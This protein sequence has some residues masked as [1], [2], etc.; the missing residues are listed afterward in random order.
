MSVV[1]VIPARGGSK[2]IPRKNLALVCGQPL[3][4]WSVR[5]AIAA[6][7]I[8]SVWVTSDNEEILALAA[9][10]GARCILRPEAISGDT[11][12]SESAWQHGLDTIEAEGVVVDWMVGMQATSPI[13]E[14]S[15]LD[16]AIDQVSREQ[17]DSLLSV[18]PVEDFFNWRMGD[19]GPEAV[20]YDFRHRR[21]RQAIE[22][23]FLENGSFYVFK[24]EILRRH[25]NRL[26]GKI[27]MYPMARHKMFQIDDPADIT[28]CEA[29]MRGYQLDQLDQSDGA[30]RP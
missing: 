11:A 20:N 29:I 4:F 6:R 22:P 17:L 3:L 27:G 1:A 15:D 30:D 28:L 7:R 10:W 12:T 13:R 9:S 8:D 21:R 23:R 19:D 14:P 25:N 16:Q 5:Q 2:G 24:P 26:G 18:T